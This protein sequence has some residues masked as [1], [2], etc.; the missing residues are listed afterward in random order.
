MRAAGSSSAFACLLLAVAAGCHGPHYRAHDA[1]GGELAAPVF[2]DDEELLDV[3]AVRVVHHGLAGRDGT[4]SWL[5]E[6]TNQDL[7]AMALAVDCSWADTVGVEVAC[8]DRRWFRLAAQQSVRV[9]FVAPAGAAALA[10]VVV[11]WDR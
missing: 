5:L 9:G 6:F 10:A 2:V 1:L 8:D 11:G 4:D 7:E 3:F